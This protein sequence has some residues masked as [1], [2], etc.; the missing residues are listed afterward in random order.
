MRALSLLLA[1]SLFTTPVLAQTNTG[2][3]IHDAVAKAAALA[4]QKPSAADRGKLFWPGL[5][6]G[7]A[8]ATM[9]VLGTTVFKVEDT[10]TGNAPANTYQACIAQKQDPIYAT[11]SC[12]GLKGKNLKLLW[13]GVALGAAG[14]VLMISSTNVSA[15]VRPGLIQFVHRVRF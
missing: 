2:R 6:L 14:A 5:A 8:G 11:N 13:G 3:P 7:V 1:A 10:S 15:E 4:A 9:A 12:E